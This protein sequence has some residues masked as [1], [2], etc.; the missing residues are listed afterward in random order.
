MSVT[1]RSKRLS[2][3]SESFYLDI[4]L[5]GQRHYE[6]LDIKINKN[7]PYRKHK[8]EMAEAKRSKRELELIANY[9]DI[10]KN[11]N[12][13]EDFLDYFDKNANT[14]HKRA[15]LN[16]FKIFATKKTVNGKLPFKILSERLVEEYK[17]FLEGKFKN[18]TAWAY[19]ITIKTIFNKA[20]KDKLIIRSPAR[21]VKI[22]LDDIARSFL[23]EQEL[24][25][26]SQT[27]SKNL[28]VKKAFMF[29]C[30]T[31][32]RISDVKKLTWSQIIENK[33]YFTQ[34]KT[35]GI[36]YLPLSETALKYLYLNV[37]QSE[38]KGD[39][40]VFNPGRNDQMNSH[41]R[42]WVKK[43]KIDKYLTFHSGRHTFA[44]LALSSGI[45]LYTVSKM[46]G[47]KSIRMTEIYA[48]IINK[49]VEDAITKLPK[50]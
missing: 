22:K 35:R 13:D 34:T 33:L 43:A 45:D 11:F 12:G 29:S 37:N 40:K 36:E 42:D 1:L 17:E 3:G 21:Y 2:N 49:T 28:E 19:M 32:L 4:Y 48:K 30:F 39:K 9:H 44:T 10:P 25:K 20:V 7:D 23:T 46:L 15:V 41:L 14:E 47:H 5:K 31:G 8:K 27:E 16:N 18:S 24:T 6:F 38:I 50:L 26:L